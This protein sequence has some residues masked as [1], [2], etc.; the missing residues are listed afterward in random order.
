MAHKVIS[1]NFFDQLE[2]A[3]RLDEQLRKIAIETALL[4]DVELITIHDSYIV[5]GKEENVLD[6]VE[7]MNKYK[8]ELNVS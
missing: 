5:E 3:R 4:C 2:I 8:G 1:K 7:R 6:F